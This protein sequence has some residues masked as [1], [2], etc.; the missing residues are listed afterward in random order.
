M[1]PPREPFGGNAEGADIGIGARQRRHAGNFRDDKRRADRGN[2][3]CMRGGGDIVLG[4]AGTG[5]DNVARNADVDRQR[6][7]RRN[8]RAADLMARTQ[9]M[10]T[11]QPREF[12]EYIM[13]GRIVVALCQ[14]VAGADIR[15]TGERQFG[16]RREDAH[17]SMML[18][19]VGRQHERRL[20]Q[21]EL[22][23]QRLHLLVGQPARVGKHRERIAAEAPV[24]EHID[25]DKIIGRHDEPRCCVHSSSSSTSMRRGSSARQSRSS[26]PAGL[27][28]KSP[29]SVALRQPDSP[30]S[31]T[32]ASSPKANHDSSTSFAVAPA[33]DSAPP[34]RAHSAER[35]RWPASA[36][37]NRR[38]LP[39]YCLVRRPTDRECAH[40]SLHRGRR[41]RSCAQARH[42]G[43]RNQRVHPLWPDQ[44]RPT[45]AMTV[46][47]QGNRVNA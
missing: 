18:R 45:P 42:A 29:S 14:H 30:A 2:Q 12:L 44:A 7:R 47:V 39:R 31:I 23:R 21:V 41:D 20:R 25:G 15:M 5:R 27:S 10:H 26:A 6:A 4:Q 40:A 19:V 11:H 16:A 36:S 17:V 34:N 46:R 22:H 24:G 3:R 9:D 28:T 35:R 33:R 1:S 37:R 8:A 32:S 43:Q 13:L 38:P